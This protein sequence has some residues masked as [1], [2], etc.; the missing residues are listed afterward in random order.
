MLGALPGACRPRP[1][2]WRS[3][4]MRPTVVAAMRSEPLTAVMRALHKLQGKVVAVAI[5]IW[6]AVSGAAQALARLDPADH[7][8]CLAHRTRKPC[9]P[10]QPLPPRRAGVRVRRP[11]QA[12]AARCPLHCH[13]RSPADGLRAGAVRTH[14][15]TLADP[16]PESERAYHPPCPRQPQPSPARATPTARRRTSSTP[17]SASSPSTAWAVRA[18]TALPNAP[19]STSGSSTTTSRA[20][21]ACSWRCWSV[22]TR[23]SAARS[24]ART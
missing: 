23:A 3:T 8:W 4:S 13:R 21:R 1:R 2:R 9:S 12:P 11:R 22:P 20:R 7:V 24:A 16:R 14:S 6:A 17:R 5:L 10:R 15:R 19:G 18:W